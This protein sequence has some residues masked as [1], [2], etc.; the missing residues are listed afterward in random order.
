MESPGNATQDP[1]PSSVASPGNGDAER[2]LVS[3]F[4][5]LH[6]RR[7]FTPATRPVN[8]YH[9]LANTRR[10]ERQLLEDDNGAGPRG[11]GGAGRE[12]D[13]PPA[14]TA[15]RAR[16]DRPPLPARAAPAAAEWAEVERRPGVRRLEGHLSDLLAGAGAM[17][18]LIA[19]WVWLI[20]VAVFCLVVGGVRSVVA[21]GR[22]LGAG[23]AA[24]PGRAA[25]RVVRLLRPR[26]LVWLPILT[27]RTVL[28]AVAVPGAVGAASWLLDNGTEGVWAAVRIAV[29]DSGLRVGAA[30]LCLMML[31]GVGEG[32]TRRIALVRRAGARLSDGAICAVAAG[33]VAVALAV[34]LAAPRLSGGPL[35][36]ADGLGW[37]PPALRGTADQ[38]R[39]EVVAAELRA[40]GSCLTERQGVVWAVRYS[41]DNPVDAPDVARLSIRDAATPGVLAT[42][43]VAADNQLAPWVEI[44]EIVA[45]DSV[46]LAY[47]RGALAHDRVRTDAATL[48]PGVV[49][50]GNGLPA[51]AE[52]VDH[53]TVLVCSAGPVP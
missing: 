20:G 44:V 32:R 12:G 43:A 11:P 38:V 8:G 13:Q 35:T 51:A 4:V 22:S 48:A 24:L 42:A 6:R 16:P 15:A 25:V 19:P 21:G 36:G 3:T 23:T 34:V 46:V 47:D 26:S 17:A 28:V 39:D 27:A 2:E 30:V 33:A 31:A 52:Q 10:I 14:A 18:A 50:G 1:V 53:S 29:W 40:V 41:H 49:T 9:Q 7:Q 45:G 5:D 37:L